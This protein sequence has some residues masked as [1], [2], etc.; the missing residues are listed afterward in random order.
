MSY[1]I[2]ETVIKGSNTVFLDIPSEEYFSYYD[3]LNK[4]SA[5]NIVKDYFINK[6]SKKDAEVMDVG[7]NEYTKSIQILAKFQS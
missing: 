7:Y 3:R 2:F 1:N 4:K 6:G 5:D